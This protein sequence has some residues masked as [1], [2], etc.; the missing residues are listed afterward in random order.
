MSLQITLTAA[1]GHRLTAWRSD[2]DGAP[3]GGIVVLHAVFGLTVHMA[4]VCDRWAVAGYAA[5]APALFDRLGPG[6][7]HPYTEAGVESGRRCFAAI[8]RTMGLADIEAAADALRPAGPVVVSGFCTGGSWAWIAAAAMDFAAQINFYGSHVPDHLALAPRCPTLMHYGDED[9]VVPPE[10]VAL[11]RAAHPDATIHVYPGAGH[12]FFNP[13]QPAA[14]DPA[15]AALAW[16]H[17]L[18]FLDRH[19]ASGA[20][21]GK[22]GG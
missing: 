13:D 17:S 8:D 21:G 5:I 12:A 4:D 15:A 3:K 16:R 9:R 19:F 14:H 22:L 10:R 1:D 11:I 6:R 2:P 7:V 20:L 18:A